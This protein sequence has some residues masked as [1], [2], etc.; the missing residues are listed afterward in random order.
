MSEYKII[1]GHKGSGKTAL[2]QQFSRNYKSNYIYLLAIEMN[3]E[4]GEL[5]SKC[6]AF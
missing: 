4:Y 3:N 2:A 5:L 6:S 1:L